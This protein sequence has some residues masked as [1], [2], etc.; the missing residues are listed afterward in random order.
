MSRR[1][2]NTSSAYD[3]EFLQAYNPENRGFNDP[4]LLTF[5]AMTEATDDLHFILLE[6]SICSLSDT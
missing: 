5:E 4:E 2:H 1:A 3:I 6:F